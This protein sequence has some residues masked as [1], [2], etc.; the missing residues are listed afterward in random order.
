MSK[1]EKPFLH[2]EF[3]RFDD[4]C[5]VLPQRIRPVKDYGNTCKSGNAG[6]RMVSI[7]PYYIAV[8]ISKDKNAG[9]TLKEIVKKYHDKGIERMKYE[10][11]VS[12]ILR[13]LAKVEN[14][15]D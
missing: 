6:V 3:T 7:V 10:N 5:N 12:R 1:E 2:V 13:E 14:A 15:V 4:E 8:E 9:M 11:Q